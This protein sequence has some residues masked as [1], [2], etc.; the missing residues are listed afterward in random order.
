MNKVTN[1]QK[2]S[3]ALVAAT[4]LALSMTWYVSKQHVKKIDTTPIVQQ[5]STKKPVYPDVIKGKVVTLKKLALTDAFDYFKAY[6]PIVR[7]H[8]ESPEKITFSY[9][10]A[11]VRELVKRMNEGLIIIFAIWDNKTETFAGTIQIREEN[12]EDPG[13]LGI[14]LNEAFW[15]K[16]LNQEAMLLASKAYFDANPHKKSYSAWVRPWNPRSFKSLLKF[17]FKQVGEAMYFN[18][19]ANVYELT[20]ETVE[21]KLQTQDGPH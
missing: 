17:G 13:Q 21:K 5:V 1:K 18:E 14:W 6:S 19:K 11:N 16:G 15:G 12:D 4:I 2:F 3:L 8:M 7:K 20:R 9:A 10:E